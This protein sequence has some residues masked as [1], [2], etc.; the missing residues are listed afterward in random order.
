MSLWMDTLKM[1]AQK[2]I[3]A[4]QPSAL[5]TSFAI[6]VLMIIATAGI[7]SYFQL[8]MKPASVPVPIAPA[9][10]NS[11]AVVVTVPAKT[12]PAPIAAARP[13]PQSVTAPGPAGPIFITATKLKHNPALVRG[14]ERFMAGS[15]AAARSEYEA[16][17]QLDSKN[18]DAL[19]GMAAISLRQ[20]QPVAAEQYFLSILES[21]PKDALAQ[22]GLIGLKGQVDS[23]HSES[24]LQTLVAAQP[25][26]SFVSFALGNLYA[27][28]G[29]W[30]E[31]KQ[32]FLNAIRTDP[33]NPDTL[34]NLAVSLDRLHQPK[35]ALEY[36]LRALALADER[37]FGF[38]KA[39]IVARLR[40]LR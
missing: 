37:P 21:D 11:P 33:D 1:V 20:G 18:A 23:L 28:Q 34:F 35:L 19:H 39:Q 9:G 25:G 5:N 36:Y 27:G 22:A 15:L 26:H 31:A 6:G 17:L 10:R 24:V 2:L 40:E 29:R 38:D 12:E 32:A 13:Q 16:L 4:Q 8:P 7:G 3:T 14:Y 30:N